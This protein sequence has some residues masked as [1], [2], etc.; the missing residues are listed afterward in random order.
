M[1]SQESTT[2][3]G[4][5]LKWTPEQIH[6]FWDWH[7]RTADSAN[8]F[9]RNVGDAVLR[10]VTAHI[11]LRGTVIDL[12][13]G[14]GYLVEKLLARNV[15]TIA[16]DASEASVSALRSKFNGRPHFLGAMLNTERVPVGD[17]TADAVFLIETLEH[18][19]TDV[20]DALLRE[21]RRMLKPGGH[22]IAT[23]PNEEDLAKGE[24]ICPNC[25]CVFHRI[26]HMRSLSTGSVEASMRAAGFAPVVCRATYFSP[27]GGAHALLE[28]VRRRWERLPQP[29]LLFIGR[30]E[31]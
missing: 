15:A 16:V 1:M 11:P 19:T 12:G 17:A 21:V 20:A 6:R 9:S 25:A 22:V 30:R 28:R 29:H 4:W 14:P 26:Q 27:L 24:I 2:S 8:Y 3:N 7:A 23:T 31:S 10:Q 5:K 13:A 18:L